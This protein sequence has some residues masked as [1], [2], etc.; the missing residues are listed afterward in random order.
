MMSRVLPKPFNTKERI[1]RDACSWIPVGRTGVLTMWVDTGGFVR[2]EANESRSDAGYHP[3][4]GL[5]LDNES[6]KV[7]NAFLRW[8]LKGMWEDLIAVI[9]QDALAGQQEAQAILQA[10][11][12]DHNG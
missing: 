4:C 12:G 3:R 1:I 10:L 5:D 11:G 8:Q 6:G 7:S 2:L 9:E